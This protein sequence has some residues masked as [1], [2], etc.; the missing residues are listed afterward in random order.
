MRVTP[1]P[2]LLRISRSA[3]GTE[4]IGPKCATPRGWEKYN[5]DG[6]TGKPKFC[7]T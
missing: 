5:G 2:L 4:R 3:E 6:R 7:I 1:V